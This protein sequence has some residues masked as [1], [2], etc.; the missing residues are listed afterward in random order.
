MSFAARPAI[1][2]SVS[3]GYTTIY[4]GTVTIFNYNPGGGVTY[5]GYDAG[6]GFGG[7][8]PT[9]VTTGYTVNSIYDYRDTSGGS[10]SCNFSLSGFGGTDPGQS[11]IYS[12]TVNGVTK[13][14]S[15]ATFYVMF[16]GVAYWQWESASTAN[17][18]GIPTSGTVSAVV[19]K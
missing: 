8:S 16:G 19:L 17:L 4:N 15:T 9:T 11:Y 7:V 2:S 18:W 1:S 14:S 12:V 13:L 3:S 10:Y 6:I 5:R